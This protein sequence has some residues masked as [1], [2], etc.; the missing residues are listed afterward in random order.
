M[1]G[2]GSTPKEKERKDKRKPRRSEHDVEYYKMCQDRDKRDQKRYKE[3]SN[4]KGTSLHN[5]IQRQSSKMQ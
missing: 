5:L 4:S 3:I 1:G 2:T